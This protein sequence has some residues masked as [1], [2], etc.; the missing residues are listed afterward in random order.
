M[1]ESRF[2]GARWKQPLENTAFHHDR[3]DDMAKLWELMK[4]KEKIQEEIDKT[5]QQIDGG[6][7]ILNCSSTGELDTFIDDFSLNPT[8]L[9]SSS[10]LHPS[11]NTRR[12][13]DYCSLDTRLSAHSV[14]DCAQ[15]SSTKDGNLFIKFPWRPP[16]RPGC[17]CLV[18]LKP[19]EDHTYSVVSHNLPPTI[20]V[21]N[22][23]KKYLENPQGPE[24]LRSFVAVVGQY[25][26][27]YYSRLQQ[28]MSAE[29]LKVVEGSIRHN[30]AAT[31][32]SFFVDLRLKEI[33]GLKAEFVLHYDPFDVYPH[34]VRVAPLMLSGQQPIPETLKGV[35]D[36]MAERMKT[37]TFPQEL[38]DSAK[39]SETSQSASQDDSQDAQSRESTIEGLSGR[40]FDV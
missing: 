21:E 11:A 26:R 1:A 29:D 27:P 12:L 25:T 8:L 13:Q 22:L 4:E 20:P 28:I 23:V 14:I 39:G 36:E 35:L 19:G 6:L 5:R 33:P 38:L 16:K 17:E 31:S 7:E 32:L 10:I 9:P 37:T 40:L 34:T 2:P 24:G 15:A 18:L 3:D 30:K